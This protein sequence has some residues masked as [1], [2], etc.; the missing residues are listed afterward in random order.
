MF[1]RGR[2]TNWGAPIGHGILHG[3]V[4]Q[5]LISFWGVPYDK[6]DRILVSTCVYIYMYVWGTPFC[7]TLVCLA[8][9]SICKAS[10]LV[11]LEQLQ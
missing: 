5:L 6:D 4:Q 7:K 11:G 9:K 1:Q 8:A 10:C 3:D 2:L